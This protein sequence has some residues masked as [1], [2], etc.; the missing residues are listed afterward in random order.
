MTDSPQAQSGPSLEDRLLS[1]HR[2]AQ[3]NLEQSVKHQAP[4]LGKLLQLDLDI[5][6]W[7]RSIRDRPEVSQLIDG[8]RGL[9]FGIYSAATGAYGQAYGG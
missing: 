7:E 6:I 2:A 4:Q 1:I 8:R 9:A 5:K 3:Q